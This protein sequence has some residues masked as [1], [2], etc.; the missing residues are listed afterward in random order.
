MAAILTLLILCSVGAC[1]SAWLLVRLLRQRQSEM[2]AL[3][4]SFHRRLSELESHQQTAPQT[5]LGRKPIQAGQRGH[6]G[7]HEH[8]VSALAWC[9]A[10]V[11]VVAASVVVLAVLS[12]RGVAVETRSTVPRP[13]ATRMT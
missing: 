8:I 13:Q 7:D 4:G 10:G 2:R 6:I 9:K 1:W 12:K 3:H 5:M 11:V